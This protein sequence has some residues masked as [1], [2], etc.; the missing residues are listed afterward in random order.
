MVWSLLLP[1]SFPHPTLGTLIPRSS[2]ATQA[3]MA[4]QMAAVE[5]QAVVVE[6]HE[7]EQEEFQARHGASAMACAC[8]C[9][10]GAARGHHLR[11][12]PAHARC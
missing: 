4:A 10:P 9:C 8:L 11:T 5:Q 7:E 12:R 1:T 6:D 3:A 2:S